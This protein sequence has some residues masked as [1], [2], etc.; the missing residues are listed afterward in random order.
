[1]I[2]RILKKDMKR[3]KSVNIILFLFITIASVFLASSVNNI[4]VIMSS[5]DYYMNYANVPE[6]SLMTTDTSEKDKIGEWIQQEGLGVKDYAYDTMLSVTEKG[7]SNAV[8]ETKAFDT[9][10]VSM[11]LG[12]MDSNYCKVFDLDGK[13]ITL[14]SG[15][16]A[17][18]KFLM[19]KNHLEVGD[20]L[21]LQVGEVKLEC[22]IV[23]V[24]KDAVYG[25]E[26][27]GLGRILIN[28]TDYCQFVQNNSSDVLGVY[29]ISAEDTHDFVQEFNRQGISA[30]SMTRSMFAMTYTFDMVM[31]AILILIGI[32]L[33]LTALL[34][35]RFTLVFTME[36]DYQEIGIMKAVGLRDFAI[37]KIYLTKYFVLVTL[38]AIL[39]LLLSL[40]VSRAMIESI[41]QNMIVEDGSTKIGVNMLCMVLIILLVMLYCYHCTGKM[42]KISAISAIR[43]GHTG[44]NYGSG[45]RN[46]LHMRKRMPVAVY[47]GMNDICR[48]VKRYLVLMITFSISFILITIP[49]NTIHTFQSGEMALKLCVNPDSAA[50][51]RKIE[52]LGESA[53]K[54]SAELKEGLKRVE[55]ELKEKGYEAELTAIPIY[56]FSYHEKGQEG[57][58]IILT[59]QLLGSDTEYLMCDEGEAPVLSNEIA[60][61]RQIL[62]ENDWK[63]GDTIESVL[64]G[65]KRNL[66]ITGTF[67]DYMQMGKSVRM[68]PEIDLSEE[69]MF[70]YSNILVNM[71]TS[72]TQEEM[73]LELSGQFPDYEWSTAWEVVDQSV[74]GI[75]QTMKRMLLPMTGMLCAVIML[76]TLLMEKLF[77][78]RE[79]GEIAILKSV[80]YQNHTI[81]MWQV[82]RMA[83]VAV[84]SMAVAV[85]LSLASNR[86]MLKPVFAIMGAEVN[87][88]VVPWQVYGVYP[89]ILLMGIILAAFTATGKVKTINI[90]E[91]NNL[92]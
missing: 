59:I 51:V 75:Q 55:N 23:C 81:R 68:N 14:D 37:K 11:Y 30:T 86:W 19:D 5:V 25:R 35:L 45:F 48:H 78:V 18:P 71:E 43:S 61:S 36:E 9:G 49:L 34:V 6:V 4:L 66:I 74:G 3:R 1:M 29:Y 26:M 90:R 33:I 72:K 85:P 7:I 80:G 91:L 32:C 76:I 40:P 15:E 84:L 70:R 16:A 39:G 92:E 12:T 31:A 47:L 73:V 62:E 50:Y 79:K 63:I 89:G 17:V 54:N 27:V 60:V 58:N 65:E 57:N 2:R 24:I 44:E 46:S 38:G 41:N 21:I 52:R 28:T 82:L 22:T 10:G 69:M 83:E 42:N 67:S 64:H 87:I 20:S 77:I 88:K 56:F 8:G 13:T 53:Y